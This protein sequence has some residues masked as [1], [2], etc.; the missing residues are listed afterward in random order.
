MYQNTSFIFILILVS[1]CNLVSDKNILTVSM[2]QRNEFLGLGT[3][4]DDLQAS[5]LLHPRSQS[6]EMSYS[7]AYSG[8]SR[9]ESVW[10]ETEFSDWSFLSFSSVVL[11]LP[12]LIPSEMLLQSNIQRHFCMWCNRILCLPIWLHLIFM[13]LYAIY[14]EGYF[15]ICMLQ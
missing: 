10:K 9:L 7:A 6:V 8:N 11:T 14:H 5:Q 13:L 15:H 4:G 1:N 2:E 12:L 3:S